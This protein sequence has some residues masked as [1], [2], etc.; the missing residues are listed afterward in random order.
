V[1]PGNPN[2]AREWSRRIR[3]RNLCYSRVFMRREL[4]CG[5]PQTPNPFWEVLLPAFRVNTFS[6]KR[7]HNEKTYDICLMWL[8][9]YNYFMY[10]RFYLK[11][12]Q[13]RS[14]TCLHACVGGV[15]AWRLHV[16]MVLKPLYKRWDP[17]NL[18]FLSFRGVILTAFGEN[19]LLATK[20]LQHEKQGT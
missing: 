19:T 5:I 1:V 14:W 9:F 18:W 7:T 2:R 4:G 12:L 10:L 8:S 15:F 6:K 17:N 3:S 20:T 13:N 16:E 11:N